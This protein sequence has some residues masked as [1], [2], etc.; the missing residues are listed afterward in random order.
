M[1]GVRETASQ[2]FNNIW[3]QKQQDFESRVPQSISWHKMD[4]AEFVLTR[5]TNCKP[6]WLPDTSR[7]IRLD[8]RR[9]GSFDF[10]PHRHTLRSSDEKWN[11]GRGPPAVLFGYDSCEDT[12]LEPRSAQ[13]AKDPG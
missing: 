9:L 5:P 7:N 1:L 3:D 2:E 13:L 4:S 11:R 8:P 12:S 10:F 6:S